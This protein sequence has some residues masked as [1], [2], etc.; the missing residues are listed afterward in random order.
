M[1][2]E[3]CVNWP[4]DLGNAKDLIH[5]AYSFGYLGIAFNHTLNLSEKC[6]K[7]RG[8]SK[9]AS[10]TGNILSSLAKEGHNCPIRYVQLNKDELRSLRKKSNLIKS[11]CGPLVPKNAYLPLSLSCH[12]IDVNKQFGS[13]DDTSLEFLQLRRLSV[14]FDHPDCVPFINAL[15][16]GP[17]NESS[18]SWSKAMFSTMPNQPYDL[19]AVRPTTQNALNSAFSSVEC[20]I[21]SIDLSSSPRLPF[22][23]KRSQV[24]LAIS[25]G[26]FFELDISQ[27]LLNKGNSRRNFFSNLLTLTRHIPHKNI[28]ITCNPSFPLDIKT[29]MDL[30]NICH[31]L[32]SLDFDRKVKLNSFDFINNNAMKALAKGTNRRSFA[33]VIL[34]KK[35]DQPDHEMEIL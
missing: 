11:N 22:I 33:S 25:R 15:S 21:I 1:S 26:I 2:F 14:I 28:I 19:V 24:N 7:L 5:K 23:L 6:N 9:K 17:C 31:V 18:D 10:S 27:C 8:D 20:D 35:D 30:S 3:L 16:R 34:I 4:G 32:L 13:E 29:P 12:N